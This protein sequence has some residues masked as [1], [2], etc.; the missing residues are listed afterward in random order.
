MIY[1]EKIQTLLESLDGK[2]R[3][4]QN[5]INGAQQ[6]TPSQAIEVLEDSRKLVER[7]SELT[8]INR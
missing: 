3:I 1:N 8:R 7:I 5:V 2:L 4:L 6:I